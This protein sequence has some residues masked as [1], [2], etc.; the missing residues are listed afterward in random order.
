MPWMEPIVREFNAGACSIGDSRFTG[1][2]LF[3]GLPAVADDTYTKGVPAVPGE[4][5][6]HRVVGVMNEPDAWRSES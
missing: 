4:Q 1:A 2:F 6:V 5:Q 3:R